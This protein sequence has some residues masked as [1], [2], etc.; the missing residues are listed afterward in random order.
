MNGT[1]SGCFLIMFLIT[2]RTARTSNFGREHRTMELV[3]E[4]QGASCPTS[5]SAD[6]II[7]TTARRDLDQCFTRRLIC[8]QA[9]SAQTDL[10]A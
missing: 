7:G 8:P 1:F 2:M 6:C 4:P 9:S 3:P 10:S 5:H